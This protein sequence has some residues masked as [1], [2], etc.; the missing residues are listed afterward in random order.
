MVQ[1]VLTVT[2]TLLVVAALY[3]AREALM[4]IYVSALIAM[5]FSPLVTFIERSGGGARRKGLTRLF[6]ILAIYIAIVGIAVLVGLMVVPP[7]IDQATSLWANMPPL[8]H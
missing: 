7:L 8:F 6:A 5:G 2:A 1:T 4:L 3:V